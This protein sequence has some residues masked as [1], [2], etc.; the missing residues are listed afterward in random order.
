MNYKSQS[1]DLLLYNLIIAQLKYDYHHSAASNIELSHNLSSVPPSNILGSIIF[2]WDKSARKFQTLKIG[3]GHKTPPKALL[4]NDELSSYTIIDLSS[5]SG[6]N[7]VSCKDKAPSDPSELPPTPPSFIS[8]S[9]PDLS[10]AKPVVTK[11]NHNYFVGQDQ[12][13]VL[14]RPRVESSDEIKDSEKVNEANKLFD[15]QIEQSSVCIQ[16]HE[17]T[18]SHVK[19]STKLQLTDNFRFSIIAY[20]SN[21]NSC[22]DIVIKRYLEVHYSK[23]LPEIKYFS[24]KE[25][26][27]AAYGKHL[28][29]FVHQ[30]SKTNDDG[31][32]IK[33]LKIE[34]KDLSTLFV[35]KKE[36]FL[37]EEDKTGIIALLKPKK[38]TCVNFHLNAI[39][40]VQ[41]LEIYTVHEILAAVFDGSIREDIE[42]TIGTGNKHSI[43]MLESS[44]FNPSKQPDVKTAPSQDEF[45]D[46]ERNVI[47]AFL[48]TVK[49]CNT[50]TLKKI[51][52]KRLSGHQNRSVEE[53]LKATFGDRIDKYIKQDGDILS[54]NH[55]DI[56]A[57]FISKD[58]LVL[59]QVEKELVISTLGKDGIGDINKFHRQAV[60]LIPWL[61][62]YTA[63][64]ILTATFPNYSDQIEER[65]SS[66]GIISIKSRKGPATQTKIHV[67]APVMF[68][69]VSEE[70]CCD[71]KKTI[72]LTDH[73]RLVIISFISNFENLPLSSLEGF[74]NSLR[75][76]GCIPCIKEC[77]ID[78]ILGLVYENRSNEY[79]ERYETLKKETPVHMFK[80]LS[81]DIS[82]FTICKNK[83]RLTLNLEEKNKIIT[84]LVLNDGWKGCSAFHIDFQSV[85]KHLDSYTVDEI[86]SVVF[87]D[88]VKH[89]IE[90]RKN[91][92]YK[93]RSLK[94]S[95]NSIFFKSISERSSVLSSNLSKTTGPSFTPST[96]S[97]VVKA[98][99]LND[100][101]RNTVIALLLTTNRIKSLTS[102]FKRVLTQRLPATESF[103]AKDILDSTFGKNVSLYIEQ[104]D[105]V[106]TNLNHDKM[107][108]QFQNKVKLK[109][110][111]ME[112]DQVVMVL[113]Q[114]RDWIGYFGFHKKI[115]S[116]IPHLQIYTV[117]EILLV[118]FPNYADHI[119][120]ESSAFGTNSLKLCGDQSKAVALAPTS[121]I[122]LA[123]S[124]VPDNHL[125][126]CS[127]SSNSSQPLSRYSNSLNTVNQPLDS[128]KS[129]PI[130][131]TKKQKDRIV[132]LLSDYQVYSDLPKLI[133]NFNPKCAA[134][135]TP[136]DIL[137]SVF[138]IPNKHVLFK[139]DDGITFCKA[140]K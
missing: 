139:N 37:N 7:L 58:K 120:E 33:M 106:L 66:Q 27:D 39:Y 101:D 107:E 88:E 112:K 47:I 116:L 32:F 122:S 81:T 36:L 127:K 48:T 61:Q 17:M 95:E 89:H 131:F 23:R 22:Q 115:L 128:S 85:A 2:E 100:H 90:E 114:H 104:T 25:I 124:S 18:L 56:D 125:Y 83:E 97:T 10:S 72:Q 5:K 24:A 63:Q 118:T 50:T 57:L 1:P 92:N 134:S 54:I 49:Q 20:L 43:R 140:K 80:I 14:R 138:G 68:S 94:L 110:N 29:S 117:K 46:H 93:N 84:L 78:N 16:R 105:T 133:N 103:L 136:N 96:T 121:R 126:V 52:D 98:L 3:S 9:V 86:L 79:I 12:Q 40:L 42:I 26:L 51:T 71:L 75:R 111:Q 41:E 91:S 137:A 65:V 135:W 55:Q 28:D 4:T 123:S 6:I 70:N 53:I 99:T 21:Y 119:I 60:S 64:E 62:V 87:D 113:K 45:S 77:S 109:L 13:S 11:N 30:I 129:P 76:Q 130:A 102:S 15:T 34:P 82:S 19:K 35:N 108:K 8:S 38:N 74:L 132:S 69:D 44:M 67:S 59:T 31:K 73:I